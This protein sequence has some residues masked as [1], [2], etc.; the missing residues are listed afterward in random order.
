MRPIRVLPNDAT[1]NNC[2]LGDVHGSGQL[3][4]FIVTERITAADRLF[5]VGDLFDKGK[6]PEAV[7]QLLQAHTNIYVTR[8]NHEDLLL[9][10][11][12]PEATADEIKGF[13]LNGG[14]WVL[15]KNTAE[16]TWIENDIQEQKKKWDIQRD[17]TPEDFLDKK[18]HLK[19]LFLKAP[20]IAVLP[21]IL[22]YV[23]HLPYIIQV[24][25]ADD[26]N[27]F[28]VC[29]ADLPISDPELQCFVNGQTKLSFWQREHITWARAPDPSDEY[30][31]NGP[32]FAVNKRNNQSMPVFCG[33]SIV[34][35]VSDCIR[36]NTNHIN[37][38]LGAYLSNCFILVNHTKGLAEAI[39]LNQDVVK[40]RE[41]P[42]QVAQ[43]I[44]AYL[45]NK[46][47]TSLIKKEILSIQKNI[48][49]LQSMDDKYLVL[50]KAMSTTMERC[51]PLICSGVENSVSILKS[52]VTECAR[53]LDNMIFE[54]SS[55]CC[56]FWHP[57]MKISNDPS[58]SYF[59]AI[60]SSLMFI[61]DALQQIENGNSVIESNQS[62]YRC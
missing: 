42:Q 14:Q 20:K 5:I 45:T 15:E 47:Q 62:V 49:D 11:C 59:E 50:G 16:A 1:G 51:M 2:L 43:S 18:N 53:L 10:A 41:I 33:H 61:Q 4:N 31:E 56:S 6:D 60:Q 12:R 26:D 39:F 25:E 48:R 44:S 21:D 29:H 17:L 52:T 27:G 28:I 54:R 58:L 57:K 36:T 38:D 19:Q 22:Q 55:I 9:N 32:Y 13:L 23:A 30:N 40:N 8:G 34:H 7:F 24:G 37:L 35:K 3:L 46:K